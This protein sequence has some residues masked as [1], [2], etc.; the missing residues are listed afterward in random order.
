MGSVRKLRLI[1]QIP[2]AKKPMFLVRRRFRLDLPFSLSLKSFRSD[3][4]LA[5]TQGLSLGRLCSV[6]HSLRC[7]AKGEY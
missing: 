5:L 6:L 4:T 3:Q 7:L 1:L 2:L